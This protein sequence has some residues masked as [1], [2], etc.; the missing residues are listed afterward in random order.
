MI[1][2]VVTTG[3]V[4][5]ALPLAAL[6]GLV[7]IVTGE[8]SSAA[9]PG[10]AMFAPSEEAVSDIPLPLLKI[11]VAQS[12]A[13]VGL[14][15][16][17]VAGIGKVESNHG[18]YSGASLGPDGVVSPPIIGIALNGGNGTAA[19]R[20]TDNGVHDRDT[21]WDRAVG[22]FQFIPS[23]WA[24]FGQD[25]NRDGVKDPHNIHDAV[26]AAV[27]HLCPHGSLTDIEAAVFSYNHSH[28]YVRLVLEWAARYTGPLSSFGPV[29]A[30]YAYPVPSEHATVAVATRSHHDYPAIDIGMPVGTSVFAMV[31]GIVTSAIGSAGVY[32]PGGSGRC[33][34]TLVVSGT[35]G[36]TY[37]Y[38]HLSAVAVDVGDP[39]TAGQAV[40]L[41][42]GQP[43]APG[44]GNTTGP[45]LHLS[46]R[47]YGQAVCPQPVML[48]IL[49]GVPIPAT[50][51]PSRGCFHP[52]PSTDWVAWLDAVLLREGLLA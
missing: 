22:P 21:V 44:A 18:R 3:V 32:V 48:S 14:P 7:T 6:F 15:W 38:C 42:G 23:S 50:A 28:E 37:T 31:D 13:C 35:D 4:L 45:H 20:D 2:K 43:G 16:Q 29:V 12:S 19:I 10:H 41:S 33:G 52:G 49:R 46:I 25:G 8:I 39:V 5:A 1:G 30:G 9:A 34:N 26:P 40:G 47:V 27:A 11:Y 24:I 17:V 51:A 36:A